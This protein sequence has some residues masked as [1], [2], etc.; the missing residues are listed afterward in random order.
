MLETVNNSKAHNSVS[1]SKSLLW[2]WAFSVMQKES[3]LQVWNAKKAQHLR[4]EIEQI[5][6]LESKMGKNVELSFYS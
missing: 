1:N 2:T 6:H 5:C 4:R 3:Y